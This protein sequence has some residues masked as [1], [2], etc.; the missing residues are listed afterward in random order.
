M[1]HDGVF[2]LDLAVLELTLQHLLGEEAVLH[3]RLFQCQTDLRFGTRGLHNVQP[4]LTR[5]LISRCQHLY[6]VAT[7]Q[8]VTDRHHTSVDTATRTLIAHL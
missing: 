8:L 1:E 2:H 7:L 5:L 4:L 3:L 6:L